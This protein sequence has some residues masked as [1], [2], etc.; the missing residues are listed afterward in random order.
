MKPF[1][2]GSILMNAAHEMLFIGNAIP[3]F[4]P[5]PSPFLLQDKGG[6]SAVALVLLLRGKEGE[7]GC[8]DR[9]LWWGTIKINAMYK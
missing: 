7:G 8:Q 9:H 4:F 3:Y 1:D 5:C 2:T 6:G